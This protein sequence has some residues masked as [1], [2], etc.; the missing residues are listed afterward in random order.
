VASAFPP[1]PM[2]EIEARPHVSLKASNV[3]M[4]SKLRFRDFDEIAGSKNVVKWPL[5][6]FSAN[7]R[8]NLFSIRAASSWEDTTGQKARRPSKIPSVMFLTLFGYFLAYAINSRKL[9]VFNIH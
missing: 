9:P 4:S 8:R 5:Q 7:N 6:R 1:L 2:P 3:G